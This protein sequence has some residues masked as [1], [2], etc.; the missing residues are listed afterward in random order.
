MMKSAQAMQPEMEGMQPADLFGGLRVTV[1]R[2]DLHMPGTEG[3]PT[4]LGSAWRGLIGWEMKRLLC[5][6]KRRNQCQSDCVVKNHCPYYLLF[7]RQTQVPGVADSPRGYIFYPP[8]AECKSRQQLEVK[9]FGECRRFLPVLVQA[10]F[11]GQRSGLSSRRIP[12]QII[13][14][15]EVRPDGQSFQLPL[16]PEA[17][18][19]ISGG[20]T[21]KQWL[22]DMTAPQNEGIA[23]STPVRLRRQGKY[24][25]EMDCQ[26]F[27]STL[28]RRLEALNCMYDG[29]A[30]IGKEI[31][32]A[33][34]RQF[35]DISFQAEVRWLDFQRFSNRQKKKVPMGGIVGR[36]ELTESPAEQ[37]A[38]WRAAEIVHVGKG[39]A[40]GLGK[41]KIEKGEDVNTRRGKDGD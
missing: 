7:E 3:L 39:A 33:L 10:I 17:L 12:Y 22:A 40:M 28:V 19:C 24:I 25:N 21:L 30:P 26:F 41:V 9:L 37:I 20:W 23:F 36:V 14:W 15:Q 27:L 4:F 29:G 11:N 5:P 8:V 34:N 1:L 35:A 13:G 2:F 16:D 38:W 32:E 6:F 18:D 31:W